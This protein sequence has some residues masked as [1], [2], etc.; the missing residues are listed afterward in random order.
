[1]S[2]VF[3]QKSDLGN[4]KPISKAITDF[5]SNSP[6]TVLELTKEMNKSIPLFQKIII[7]LFDT[8]LT[9]REICV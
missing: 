5:F 3:R 8:L 1:M 7:A 9:N 6:L 2:F 4:F